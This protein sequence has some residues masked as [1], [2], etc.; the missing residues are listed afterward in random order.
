M[1]PTACEQSVSNT[2]NGPS[3]EVPGGLISRSK[4]VVGGEG[5]ETPDFLGVNDTRAMPRGIQWCPMEREM[6]RED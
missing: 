1:P 2:A 3:G 4:S 5:L 6:A